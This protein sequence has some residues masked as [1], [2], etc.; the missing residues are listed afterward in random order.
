[1]IVIIGLSY[2]IVRIFDYKK[3]KGE[4]PSNFLLIETSFMPRSLSALH[5][6]FYSLIIAMHSR[7][8][9]IR[10]YSRPSL[11]TFTSFYVSTIV[12]LAAHGGDCKE[13]SVHRVETSPS[14]KLE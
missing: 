4:S 5:N 1:M 13:D 7:L 3:K 9:F 8:H 11:L 6:F 12:V 10:V 14:R 2:V